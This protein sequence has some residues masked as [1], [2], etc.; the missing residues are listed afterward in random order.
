[1][2]CKPN[3]YWDFKPSN[4]IWVIRNTNNNYQLANYIYNYIDFHKCIVKG[5][6][7]YFKIRGD[8]CACVMK[9]KSWISHDWKPIRINV[10]HPVKMCS[11]S[12]L[13]WMNRD[14]IRNINWVGNIKKIGYLISFICN[15]IDLNAF[16]SL[17]TLRSQILYKLHRNWK[18]LHTKILHS[19]VLG[20]LM[21]F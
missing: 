10:L 2:V 14:M 8:H 4:C 1:M 20:V 13:W 3:V 18:N 7:I 6:E 15:Y 5:V 11:T 9:I 12:T 17:L 19:N 21:H 16:V